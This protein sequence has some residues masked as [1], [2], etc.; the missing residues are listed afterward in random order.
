MFTQAHIAR[1]DALSSASATTKKQ[2]STF[3]AKLLADGA[4]NE[5]QMQAIKDC[6]NNKVKGADDCLEMI[7][8]FINAGEIDETPSEAQSVPEAPETLP[9]PPATVVIETE[10][11][12]NNE[13][14]GEDAA[15]PDLEA[16]WEK[17]AAEKAAAN[18]PAKSGKKPRLNK[19]NI[20]S[21]CLFVWNMADSMP[22]AARKDVVAACVE[23]GVAL[24]TAKTQ[25]QQWYTA[26]KSSPKAE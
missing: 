3:A 2:V 15:E 8:A 14:V 16:E 4:I 22:G 1:L 9:E 19:S 18:P 21:P 24:Y 23:A 5:A 12:T 17:M 10:T 13:G 26:K 7:S 6:T 11:T 20:E 25:Y